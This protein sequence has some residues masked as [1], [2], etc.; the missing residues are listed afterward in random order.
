[1]TL[2]SEKIGTAAGGVSLALYV[3]TISACLELVGDGG[4][5]PS[6]AT[7]SSASLLRDRDRP[8]HRG[9]NLAVIRICPRLTEDPTEDCPRGS[10][11]RGSKRTA[12]KDAGIRD[13]RMYRWAVVR[14]GHVTANGDGHRPG[15]VHKVL[16]ADRGACWVR[17]AG[18]G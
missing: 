8:L 18:W 7:A 13:H 3:L 6:R 1:M 17:R 4:E 16:D 12:V 11:I 14:P 2:R 10:E 9:V 5:E 15:G